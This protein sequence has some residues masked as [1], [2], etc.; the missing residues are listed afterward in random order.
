MKRLSTLLAAVVCA[1]TVHAST[2]TVTTTAD[3][4]AGSLRTALT[5]AGAAAGPHTIVFH[6]PNTDPNLVGGV[7]VITPTNALPILFTS[8]GITLDGASQT[9]FGGDTNPSGPEISLNGNNA[10]GGLFLGNNNKLINLNIR[11]FLG[12]GLT[13]TGG[14]NNTVR[15]C[16]IGTD[17]TGQTAQPNAGAGIDCAGSRNTFGGTNPSDRNVICGNSNDG[18]TLRS[19]AGNNIIQGNYFGT[20]ATGTKAISGSADGIECLGPNNLI[21]GNTPAARNIFAGHINAAGVRLAFA[22]VT[23]TIVRGN[24][25]GTDVTGTNVLANR[26]GIDIVNGANGTIIDGNLITGNLR[27]GIRI[28]TNSLGG[29]APTNN[30]V[31]GNSIYN[32]GNPNQSYLGISFAEISTTPTPNDPCDADDGNQHLQNYPIISN[33]TTVPGGVRIQGTLNSVA[34]QSYRIEFFANDECDPTGYGEGQY[35]LGF[36]NVTTT[37]GCTATI[38]STFN[39][40]IQSPVH[41]TA[42]ATDPENNTSEFG[43]CLQFFPNPIQCDLDPGTALVVTNTPHT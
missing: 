6:I 25:F 31:T 27:A 9:T 8:G 15:G 1:G 32:N 23:G 41:L 29:V 13:M 12:Y 20:D 40:S 3:S 16:Y 42:T 24:Y 11:N 7:F 38:D 10:V 39:S 17:P 19:T 4:G 21:G 34:S 18:I 2:F 35:Y 26:E 30:I 33:A 28:N 43:P 14:T 37:G 36:T 22:T 5:S